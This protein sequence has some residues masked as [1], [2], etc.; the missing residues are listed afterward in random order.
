MNDYEIRGAVTANLTTAPHAEAVARCPEGTVAWGAGGKVF[1][2]PDA[3]PTGQLGL[4][5]VRTSA[6]LDS[7]RATAR[8]SAD[9][10][11]G[12]W[13][14][15][16]I[17]VCADRRITVP[18]NPPSPPLR[19]SGIRADG[20]VAF[21]S[22][23]ATDRCPEGLR[24]HG[25]GGG[26]GTSDSGPVWLRS[27]TPRNDLRGVSVRMSGVPTSGIVAHQTCASP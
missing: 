7:A 12:F 2:S 26:A 23:F 25:L 8:E 13:R 10:F 9:G 19:D 21:F 14:V 15:R 4:Q 22:T 16:S 27:I 6:P 11:D 20:A 3:R 17:V 1:A 24:A 18:P 5:L